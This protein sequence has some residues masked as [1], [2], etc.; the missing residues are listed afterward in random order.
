MCLMLSFG[1]RKPLSSRRTEDVVL[2]LLSEG[3]RR[4]R[5]HIETVVFPVWSGS[6][7]TAPKGDVCWK[8][9]ELVPEHLPFTEQLR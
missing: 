8:R 3:V 6:E 7:G 9:S 2:E 1:S 4:V 5:E